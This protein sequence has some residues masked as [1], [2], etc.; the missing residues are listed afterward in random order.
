MTRSIR[1]I[2][3]CCAALC[4]APVAASGP[5]LEPMFWTTFG[6][7]QWLDPSN[8]EPMRLP[9]GGDTVI[10]KNESSYT[11]GVGSSVTVDRILVRNG[12]VTFALNSGSL[13]VNGAGGVSAVLGEF[14]GDMPSMTI[15]D[16]RFI[17]VDVE[18]GLVEGTIASL[19]VETS[20]GR[21]NPAGATTIGVRGHGAFALRG[22]ARATIPIPAMT[23]V[24]GLEH[25]AA[26]ALH[27]DGA[28]TRWT[29]ASALHA[30]VEGEA[31]V[32]VTNGARLTT[33]NAVLASGEASS[34]I[35]S[36]SGGTSIWVVDG[37]LSMGLGGAADLTIGE[38]ATVSAGSL[39]LGANSTITV[40]IGEPGASPG[41]VVAQNASLG[42]ALHIALGAEAGALSIGDSFDLLA[43]ASRTG[44]F[45]LAALPDLAGDL[46]LRIRYEPDRI[47]A[48][49]I[50]APGALALLPLGLL[51]RR[52]R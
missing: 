40:A 33:G 32:T 6:D 35:A 34:A 46:H 21:Y 52:R 41:V 20:L 4:I 49:V 13:G 12:D 3:G 36:L 37:L 24:L 7:G 42:G 28:G 31:A 44:R 8:W 17:P 30:G 15:R 18:V 16:G 48:V 51:A 45:D 43:F 22:G 27:V 39:L 9:L 11:V 19:T 23:T 29:Q 38:H 25:G 47:Y 14:E 1:A 2:A 5:L 10:F 50:P 26:G